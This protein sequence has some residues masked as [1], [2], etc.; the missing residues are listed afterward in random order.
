MWTNTH[1]KI[2]EENLIDNFKLDDVDSRS[3]RVS[4][5][6]CAHAHAQGSQLS[7]SPLSAVPVTLLGPSDAGTQAMGV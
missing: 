6:A 2:L 7:H 4:P 5:L 3:R 1:K